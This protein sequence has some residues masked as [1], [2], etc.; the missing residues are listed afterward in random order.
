MRP[1][2]PGLG[3]AVRYLLDPGLF[4]T[5]NSPFESIAV[6]DFCLRCRG[7]RRRLRFFGLGVSGSDPDVVRSAE[8]VARSDLD[9]DR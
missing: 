4:G 2:G 7:D 6:L 9:G 1:N 8:R 5:C 3:L